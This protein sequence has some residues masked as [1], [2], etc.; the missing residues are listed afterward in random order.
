M[1]IFF[2]ELNSILMKI[3]PFVL[4]CKYGCWSHERKHS[5]NCD[6]LKTWQVALCHKCM[7][8]ILLLGLSR[9]ELQFF[10][11]RHNFCKET[12]KFYVP[13]QTICQ[14]QFWFTTTR[15][16]WK[17]IKCNKNPLFSNTKY[18]IC[19][20]K[21][22]KSLRKSVYQVSDKCWPR[23][24]SWKNVPFSE[25]DSGILGKIPSAPRWTSDLPRLL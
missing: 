6:D 24:M 8:I 9:G 3:L 2:W 16:P 23:L 14:E 19:D 21:N 1:K 4:V 18:K 10:A 20:I 5:Y 12:V 15:G 11:F 13:W 7:K 22:L 25:G 17:S